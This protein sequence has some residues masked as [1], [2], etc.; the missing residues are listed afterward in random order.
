MLSEDS[1]KEIKLATLS[2]LATRKKLDRCNAAHMARLKEGASTRA[3]STT[4][5][6][7]SARLACELERESDYLL[8]IV[9]RVFNLESR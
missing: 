8:S 1:L 3:R 2:A 9:T 6:A 7:N 4:Y 5:A